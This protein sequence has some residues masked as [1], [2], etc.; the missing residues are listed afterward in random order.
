ME[1]F[2]T[3]KFAMGENLHKRNFSLKGNLQWQEIYINM[4]F[5]FEG[6]FHKQEFYNGKK[7]QPEGIL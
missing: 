6:N 2:N 4:N 5:P 1:F 7:Y 3:R